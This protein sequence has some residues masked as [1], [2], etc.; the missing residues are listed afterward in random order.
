M[1]SAPSLLFLKRGRKHPPAAWRSR[2]V[3][4]IEI[5]APDQLSTALL[6][7]YA[8]PVFPA[9]LVFGT[10]WIVRLQPPASGGGWVLELL[11]LVERWLE[12]AQLPCANVLYGGRSYMIRTSAHLALAAPSTSEA[13]AAH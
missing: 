10:S 12:S 9:E 13:A 3:R 1:S 4:M 2:P 7:E 5:V 11:T 6:L 8:A